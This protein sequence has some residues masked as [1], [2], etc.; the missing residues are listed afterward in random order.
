[1]D[2][3]FDLDGTLNDPRDGII[4][5]IQCALEEVEGPR[6]H[7]SELVRYIGPPLQ[8]SFA[9]MLGC[10][11]PVLIQR[12]LDSHRHRYSSVGFAQARVYEGAPEALNSLAAA[13]HRCLR[14]L[15]LLARS[16]LLARKAL[17]PGFAANEVDDLKNGC[18]LLHHKAL[19]SCQ[20][21]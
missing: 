7:A 3:L 12:A 14:R 21:Q 2:I 5:S 9:Q 6:L 17:M 8:Q 10:A 19:S 11:D 1:M 15:L 16:H 18:K 20:Q 4:R 13:G